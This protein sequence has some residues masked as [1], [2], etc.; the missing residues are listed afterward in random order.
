MLR[1]GHFQESQS[2]LVKTC[3]LMTIVSQASFLLHN[4]EMLIC[5]GTLSSKGKKLI[6]F[7]TYFLLNHHALLKKRI[8]FTN[9]TSFYCF[10]SF[11]YRE[12]C[13]LAKECLFSPISNGEL[14]RVAEQRGWSHS[15][16]C[17]KKIILA[18]S[19][20]KEDGKGQE[21]SQGD[22]LGSYYCFLDKK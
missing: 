6:L 11:H 9:S 21:R 13:V 19:R 16:L 8:A 5:V 3:V 17:F 7:L 10:I 15:D 18:S 22:Q 14:L 1:K 4:L 20:K 2:L 12:P